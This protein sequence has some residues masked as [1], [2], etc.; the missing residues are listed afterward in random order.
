MTTG[1]HTLLAS[2]VKLYKTSNSGVEV[3]L[4]LASHT[5]YPGSFPSQG[6]IVSDIVFQPAF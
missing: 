3:G 4:L 1:L 5:V 6:F 2:I